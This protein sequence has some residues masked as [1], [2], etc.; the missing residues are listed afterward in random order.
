MK[1]ADR[2]HPTRRTALQAGLSLLLP[3]SL[4]A[5]DTADGIDA[6]LER[7]FR[8][9]LAEHG[10]PGIA[11]AVTHQ[12]RR[13]FASFGVAS[14][15]SGAPVDEHTLFEIGSLSKPFTATFAGWAVARG[16]MRL[17]EHPGRY[18]PPLRG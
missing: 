3:S 2:I 14:R 17:E 6:M 1:P 11:V 7:V 18:L 5:A 16:A 9:L 8:P 15:S 4:R 12:G 13:R 10:I